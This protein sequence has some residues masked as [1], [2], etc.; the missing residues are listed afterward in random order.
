MKNKLLIKIISISLIF[1]L[2]HCVNWYL[3]CLKNIPIKFDVIDASFSNKIACNISG[4]KE[5][6]FKFNIYK[7][8]Y[9]ISISPCQNYAGD[10][11][12]KLS[13]GSAIRI[14][15]W[16]YSD[17]NG[18]L[19]PPKYIC[20]MLYENYTHTISIIVFCNF[21]NQNIQP[22]LFNEI[23]DSINSSAL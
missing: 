6:D 14:F 12:Q 2:I 4:E 5:S 1:L 18:Q 8:K 13:D 22:A 10:L 23:V 7:G 17:Y 21:P 20:G 9:E 19:F 16:H 15:D 3:F 11:W